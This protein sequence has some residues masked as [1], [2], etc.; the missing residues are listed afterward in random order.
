M[1]WSFVPLLMEDVHVVLHLCE[2]HLLH[3]DGFPAS[4]D[5]LNCSL[6]SQNGFLFL[7]DPLNLLLDS[8]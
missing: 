7:L 6:P 1:R 2:P 5:V 4:F 3:V 8:G